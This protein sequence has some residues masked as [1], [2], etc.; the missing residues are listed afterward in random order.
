[1]PSSTTRRTCARLR[2]VRCAYLQRQAKHDGSRPRHEEV[3][4]G[5]RPDAR[6]NPSS[7]NQTTTYSTTLP[8]S[9]CPMAAMLSASAA[10][11]L[12][13]R[14]VAKSN[15]ARRAS[16]RCVLPAHACRAGCF[17]FGASAG[18]DVYARSTSAARLGAAWQPYTCAAL[19]AHQSSASRSTA[20]CAPWPRCRR[21]SVLPL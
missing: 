1:M 12:P 9:A 18:D 13:A 5:G 8:A 19:C 21:R 14:R 2:R 15:A 3:T 16:A 11:V 10:L 20:S 6:G 4:Q 17:A 7:S